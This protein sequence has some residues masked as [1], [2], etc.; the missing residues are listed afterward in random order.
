MTRVGETDLHY[1]TLELPRDARIDYKFYVDKVWMM[2][3]LNPNT[4]TGGFGPNSE[5]SMPDYIFPGE[6]V[7][8]DSIPHG[9]LEVHHFESKIMTNSRNV[10]VYTPAGYEQGGAY[11]AILVHDG[12]DYISLGSMVD[13]LDN[14]IYAGDIP[15]VVAVFIDPVDRNF[16]YW[17][18]AE[19]MRLVVEELLPFIRESYSITSDPAKTAVMGAS[20]GGAISLFISVSHPDIFGNCGS[21]SGAFALDGGKLFGIMEKTP[22][23]PVDFYLDT[24]VIGDL[25]DDNRRMKEILE[26]KDYRFMYQEFNEGHSWGN[27]RA[28]LD[29]ML[30][31]FWGK[32][33]K[34]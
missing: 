15:P 1:I 16:E 18:N 21:Q 31:F 10:H 4:V 6:I 22:R 12:G 20:L 11:H 23:Q 30:V 32:E 3:P 19:Y 27:W 2:D 13:V 25:V 8:N 34:K 28:H 9:A 14:I 26:M 5:L 17:A 29:D 24:G 7:P 33:A